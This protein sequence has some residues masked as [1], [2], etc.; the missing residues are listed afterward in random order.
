M[1]LF[2][3]KNKVALVTGGAG[4]LG[5]TMARSL[6]EAGVKVAIMGRTAAKLDKTVAEFKADGL[7]AMALPA[8][9][10][11]QEA[12]EAARSTLED[13]W[14]ALHILINA[15]GGNAPEATIGPDKH[16]FDL[17]IEA[18]TRVNA[19]NLQGTVLP[20]L[21]FGP[22]MAKS[23][24]AS[25]INISSMASPQA[26]TRVV[27]YST[28]KAAIDN[29][30]RWMAVELAKRHGA[31]MRVNAIAPGFFIADQNRRLLL[32]ENGE[33]TARGKTIIDNTP[34]GRFGEAEELC[35]IVHWLSSDASGFVTGT[36][37]P[38]DGGFSAFSGV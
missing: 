19:L 35:G 33:L 38:V 27:A 8:D 26:I 37:I 1:K 24:K 34:M 32:E 13:K 21:V 11:K 18:F 14:G 9:V 36:V 12:L 5:S 3:L 10:L 20:T 17:S 15:A 25:I 29:F 28:G 4:V 6:A 31:Q 2:D 22:L 23:E 16:P 7:E 30:T